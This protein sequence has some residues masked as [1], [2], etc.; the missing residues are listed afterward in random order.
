MINEV[1]A[2]QREGRVRVGEVHVDRAV[3]QHRLCRFHGQLSRKPRTAFIHRPPRK[4]SLVRL[5]FS[6]SR[7]S[8]FLSVIA[9]VSQ[10]PRDA[11]LLRVRLR[12][13]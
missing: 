6:L 2:Q 10:M 9:H 1:A 5:R 4:A 12:L 11:Y 3:S 8:L 13:L 7:V